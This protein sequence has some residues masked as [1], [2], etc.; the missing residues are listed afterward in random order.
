MGV[1]GKDKGFRYL[2]Q[3]G[4][5]HFHFF[6]V[7][8][9]KGSE[10]HGDERIR[11]VRKHKRLLVVQRQKNCLPVLSG[12]VP[13]FGILKVKKNGSVGLQVGLFGVAVGCVIRVRPRITVQCKGQ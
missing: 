12:I 7:V 11:A 6:G 9:L 4:A 1:D 10:G 5:G 8:P 13:L 2:L 3:N